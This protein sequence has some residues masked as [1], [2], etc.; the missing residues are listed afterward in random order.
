MAIRVTTNAIRLKQLMSIKEKSDVDVWRIGEIKK[1]LLL[2]IA[3]LRRFSGTESAVSEIEGLLN[4][5]K[6]GEENG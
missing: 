1:A 4:K 3:E 6:L 5:Y 2:E